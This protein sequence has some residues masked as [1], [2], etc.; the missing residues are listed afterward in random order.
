MKPS[1]IAGL[2]LIGLGIVGLVLGRFSST[3]EETVTDVGPA[4]ASV[5]EKH[6]VDIPDITG[7]GPILAG[8]LL[9][10]LGRKTV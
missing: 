10:Y 9:V 5:N 3:T 1:A 4:T 7:I 8:A 6:L 2:F